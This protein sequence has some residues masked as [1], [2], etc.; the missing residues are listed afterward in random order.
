MAWVATAIV[1]SAV[2]GGVASNVAASK[3][4][5]AA[6]NANQATLDTQTQLANQQRD[7]FEPFRQLGLGALPQY[8]A[9]LGLPRTDASN[10]R[11]SVTGNLDR[12]T[13]GGIDGMTRTRGVVSIPQDP[14][15]GLGRTQD[16]RAGQ[17]FEMD[18]SPIGQWTLQE[19]LKMQN[20]Q[21]AARGLSGSGG[22]SARA[23][24]LGMQVRANDYQ[25]Q[26]GRILDALKI[27]T[28]AASSAGAASQ[29]L[30]NQVGQSGQN[31]QNI[32]AGQSQAN[33]Q[34][35]QGLG[36]LPM[37]YM[38][39]QQKVQ[40]PGGGS[41]GSSSYDSMLTTPQGTRVDSSRY[42]LLN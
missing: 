5:K 7:D 28:G 42:S 30:S 21:D 2:I 13:S 33:Q 26:Y 18:L 14:T 25:Q 32:I 23:G 35:W 20:R 12:V 10:V 38:N 9:M 31:Q 41:G 39:Y 11:D 16:A 17:P 4:A 19:S 6:T 27:G 3:G 36:S 22:A 29:Q 1:G 40:M 15:Q 37:D 8:R 24:E 34:L